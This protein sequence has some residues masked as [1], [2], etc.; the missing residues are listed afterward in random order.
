MD[1][2]RIDSIRSI[3]ALYCMESVMVRWL[4]GIGGCSLALIC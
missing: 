4:M 3:D 1:I 2:N